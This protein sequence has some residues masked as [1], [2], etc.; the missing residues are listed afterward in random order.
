MVVALVEG[1]SWSG[2]RAA[3]CEPNGRLAWEKL[4]TATKQTLPWTGRVLLNGC[5]VH[6]FWNGNGNGR[7]YSS[8]GERNGTVPTKQAL[9]LSVSNL[10]QRN[11]CLVEMV[12]HWRQP[13]LQ[14]K[15]FRNGTVA[16][17]SF[18]TSIPNRP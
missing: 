1:F 16:T 3:R 10:W 4:F 11:G 12:D 18:S 6:N 13:F 7:L 5:S 9:N 15:P 14:V 2:K 17:S 8:M